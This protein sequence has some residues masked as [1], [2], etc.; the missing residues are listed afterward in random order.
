ML[1]FFGG[2]PY[3]VVNEKR[4]ATGS[5]LPVSEKCNGVQNSGRRRFSPNPDRYSIINLKINNR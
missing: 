2:H 4:V 3:F 1:S 5:T